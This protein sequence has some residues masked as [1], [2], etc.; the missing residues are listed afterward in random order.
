MTTLIGHAAATWFMVG[1][2][3]TIQV[4]HYPLFRR[5]DEN[6]FAAYETE[7]A[8]RMAR[9]LAVPAVIEVVTGALLVWSRPPDVGLLPVLVSGSLLAAV[10]IIT[11]LVQVPEHQRLQSGKNTVFIDR[12]VRTNWIRTVL[13]SARGVLVGAMLA[14]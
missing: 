10:W 1:L 14:V 4:V 5:V 13:W 12:L 8:L 6:G 9:L 7:H 3:W 11:A 2:I